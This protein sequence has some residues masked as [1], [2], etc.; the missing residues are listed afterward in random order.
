MSDNIQPPGS[1]KCGSNESLNDIVFDV[2]FKFDSVFQALLNSEFEMSD[3]DGHSAYCTIGRNGRASMKFGRE[4]WPEF[5]RPFKQFLVMHELFH[6]VL[7]HFDR[8]H[9]KPN[10]L[11]W[12]PSNKTVGGEEVGAIAPIKNIAGDFEINSL[13]SEHYKTAI[14]ENQGLIPSDFDLEEGL[15]FEEYY[16]L[17]KKK[18]EESEQNTQGDGDG[19]G[20][21]DGGGQ[22][23]SENGQDGDPGNGRQ[24]GESQSGSGDLDEKDS[25]YQVNP[26]PEYGED[27]KEG[28]QAV[29]RE[30]AKDLAK[31]TLKRL[32]EDKGFSKY[33]SNVFGDLYKKMTKREIDI[34]RFITRTIANYQTSGRRGTWTKLNRRLPGISPGKKKLG[35][36]ELTFIIDTSGSMGG[37]YQILV[38]LVTTMAEKYEVHLYQ[39]DTQVVDCQKLK[40]KKHSRLEIHGGGGTNMIPAVEESLKKNPKNQIFLFTDGD[41]GWSD[42]KRLPTTPRQLVVLQDT[43]GHG[44]ESIEAKGNHTL[45]LVDYKNVKSKK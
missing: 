3:I 20:D 34:E 44:E 22:G 14:K 27:V 29:A 26:I 19:D 39:V 32:S 16:E 5:S 18:V 21:G 36:P 6:F 31:A 30:M 17:L 45:V 15:T 10:Y 12:L 38:D 7:M 33:G 2:S 9:D 8:L 41:F 37:V 25:D 4:K 43:S 28:D 40:R 23:G 13:L 1:G 42:F 24:G 11:I 35:F